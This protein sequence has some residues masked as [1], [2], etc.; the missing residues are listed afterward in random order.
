MNSGSRAPKPPDP[1]KTAA[2]QT[3]SNQS[4][5]IYEQMLNMQ[6][7]RTPY[8]SVTWQPAGTWSYTDPTTGKL[9]NVP[10]FMASTVLSPAQQGLLDQE[11]TF[12]ARYNQMAIDQAGRVK[13]TLSTPFKYDPGVHESWAGGLYDKLN[14]DSI[15]RNQDELAQSLANRGLNIGTKAYDQAMRDFTEGNQRARDQFMLDSYGT[16]MNT[17]LTERN[18]PLKEGIAL[19]GGGQITEPTWLQGPQSGVANTDVAGLTNQ[20]YAQKLAASQ[21]QGGLWSALGQIGGAALGG[22]MASDERVKNVKSGKKGLSKL[23]E[24]EWSYKGSDQVHR[25]PTAQ[26]VERQIPEAVAEVDGVKYVNWNRVPQGEK[27][28]RDIARE[29]QVDPRLYGG[30]GRPMTDLPDGHMVK[31]GEMRLPPDDPNY[32][33]RKALPKATYQ[34]AGLK[35]GGL[36]RLGKAVA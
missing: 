20:A 24:K 11:Q 3:G 8:G 29:R 19:M 30:P 18:Q 23:A 4:T 36:Q 25:T 15:S 13:D 31:R 32:N 16:G 21:Q 10:K 34:D 35:R 5:A 26:D 7:Q 28:A 27:Y 22:W 6:D 17:A 1:V 9:I 2:A 14:R 33:I 12:D